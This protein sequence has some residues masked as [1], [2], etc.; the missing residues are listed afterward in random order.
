MPKLD[1][2][3]QFR[4]SPLPV[5][6]L[7]DSDV[8]W[9]YGPLHTAVDPV[10]I[11]RA[12]TAEDYLG[13]DKTRARGPGRSSKG[14]LPVKPIL[15]H[16]SLSDILSVPSNGAALLMSEAASRSSSESED[17]SNEEENSADSTFS[18]SG[19][20]SSG[21]GTPHTDGALTPRDRS[22]LAKSSSDS[23]TSRQKPHRRK[24]YSPPRAAVVSAHVANKINIRKG[25]V[26][27]LNHDSDFYADGSGSGAGTPTQESYNEGL[28]EGA[29]DSMPSLAERRS[30]SHDS[31]GGAGHPV[32]ISQSSFSSHQSSKKRHIAFNH[33]VDQCISVDVDEEQAARNAT[34]GASVSSAQSGANKGTARSQP[35][36]NSLQRYGSSSS[37]S[38]GLTSSS[39]SSS[40][41]SDSDTTDEEE[42][43]L[44]FKS[45]SPRSPS[46]VK[47]FLAS[48]TDPNGPRGGRSNQAKHAHGIHQHM[49]PEHRTIVR[50]EATTLKESEL[51]P[52]PT[53]IVV[54]EDGRV[55]ALYGTE[56]DYIFDAAEHGGM[57]ISD[58]AE[59]IR[60]ASDD[61]DVGSEGMTLI[62]R[63]EKTS[64]M[65][66]VI[67][68]DDLDHYNAA[69]AATA[70][71]TAYSPYTTSSPRYGDPEASFTKPLATNVSSK[72]GYFSGPDIALDVDSDQRLST[73]SQ[74]NVRGG[75]AVDIAASRGGA[76]SQ[77]QAS[78]LGVN[79]IASPITTSPIPSPSFDNNAL[80]SSSPSGKNGVTPTKS[81][82]KK[83]L[84]D[85]NATGESYPPLPPASTRASRAHAAMFTEDGEEVVKS[86]RSHNAALPGEEQKEE[87]IKGTGGEHLALLAVYSETSTPTLCPLTASSDTNAPSTAAPPS[88]TSPL[89]VNSNNTTYGEP[90]RG[91]SI[92][93]GSSSSSL[94]D[95]ATSGQPVGTDAY[96]LA[97]TRSA[98]GTSLS[99]V[100]SYSPPYTASLNSLGTGTAT[101]QSQPV[102]IP[103]GRTRD[104]QSTKPSNRRTVLYSSSDEED[105][106]DTQ[107]EH[108][109][110]DAAN[111][112]F[113][114]DVASHDFAR[115]AGGKEE[116]VHFPR[117]AASP[118]RP[119]NSSS[120]SGQQFRHVPFSR[121][122]SGNR[123]EYEQQSKR[124]DSEDFEFRSTVSAANVDRS[125]AG[126]SSGGSPAKAASGPESTLSPMQIV[127]DAQSRAGEGEG[128]EDDEAE[129]LFDSPYMP[130]SPTFS[131]GTNLP[132][133]ATIGAQASSPSREKGRDPY[134]V[135]WADHEPAKATSEVSAA[136]SSLLRNLSPPSSIKKSSRS[137][138]SL[139]SS[140]FNKT[141]P[142]YKST[143]RTKHIRSSTEDVE[144]D[145][146]SD[147]ANN[148][149]SY[150]YGFDLSEDDEDDSAARGVVG[151]AF[152][153]VGALW[154]VGSGMLWRSGSTA[155]AA[156]DQ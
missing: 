91:R 60:E 41:S 43:V 114:L 137:A 81:I 98:S 141:Q 112:D 140:T 49:K 70:T 153:L 99:P 127:H 2:S 145:E 26:D 154:N 92:S 87:Q 111:M 131:S 156:N 8:T 124:E 50:M 66:G 39:S 149:Y 146:L 143:T 32:P 152:D 107:E 59:R 63:S 113:Q 68:L 135:R 17:M 65:E 94:V 11:K 24:K 129:R 12:A 20:F 118:S 78:N 115:T 144:E 106:S 116:E 134:Q 33:R 72:E 51:L 18:S 119:A 48:P 85:Q 75:P 150:G 52:G 132:A 22:H 109:D 69:P 3:V 101:M 136:R 79:I 126:P 57:D 21:E 14:S 108:E 121:A 86:P 151:R 84:R 95:R 82:L 88:S 93:R 38:G 76:G 90:A 1:H 139:P 89:I 47:P 102:D 31:H 40:S 128:L 58:W 55:T 37:G 96:S 42:H 7:K 16:R 15:K 46:F 13:L 36:S 103:R 25:S 105:K 74:S 138:S 44:T 5:L 62:E 122:G 148:G 53:P 155:S 30:L 27:A 10:P 61:E 67:V 4:V 45:S 64:P 19:T 9:L 104:V 142:A 125:F 77:P 117:Q 28:S 56:D 100:P 6:R 73:S 71:A 147:P 110:S 83:N 35:Y 80:L 34:S 97:R 29:L 130:S 133:L 54:M 120:V 123:P 23:A